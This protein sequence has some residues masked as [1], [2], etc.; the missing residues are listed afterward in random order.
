MNS[1]K[2]KDLTSGYTVDGFIQ[3]LQVWVYY[4]LPE[5]GVTHGKPIPD[6]PSQLFMAYKGGKECRLLKMLSADRYLNFTP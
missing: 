1:L 3:V 6:R 2:G 4:V 5:F